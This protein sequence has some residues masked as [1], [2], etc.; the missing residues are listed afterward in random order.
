MCVGNGTPSLSLPVFCSQYPQMIHCGF[1]EAFMACIV[2]SNTS[3]L[4]CNIPKLLPVAVSQQLLAFQ[5]LNSSIINPEC[6]RLGLYAVLNSC[7][8]CEELLCVV[9]YKL[10][11]LTWLFCHLQCA[12]QILKTELHKIQI[13][14]FEC[15]LHYFISLY[16][17]PL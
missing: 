6:A 4:G 1:S 15:F 8:N 16:K 5:S 11:H 10:I 3:K 14:L 9:S 13:K 17:L 2:Y 7:N 12:E